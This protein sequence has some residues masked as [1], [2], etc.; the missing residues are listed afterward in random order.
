MAGL[1]PLSQGRR[2]GRGRTKQGS[3]EGT[4]QGQRHPGVPFFLV[5]SFWAGKKKSLAGQGETMSVAVMKK[6]KK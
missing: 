6:L 4:P 2:I 3:S 1:A 5:T